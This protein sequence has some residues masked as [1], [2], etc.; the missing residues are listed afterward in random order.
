MLR[1][2]SLML[3][4]IH[5][6]AAEPL[7]NIPHAYNVKISPDGQYLAAL[8]DDTHQKK[9]TILATDTLTPIYHFAP[10]DSQIGNFHWINP[11]RVVIELNERTGKIAPHMISEL[12]AVNYD[13]GQGQ[14]IFGERSQN[15]IIISGYSAHWLSRLSADDEHILIAKTESTRLGNST[16]VTKINVY[17]GGERTIKRSSLDDNTF[18]LDHQGNPRLVSGIDDDGKIKV[19]YSQ[20]YGEKWHPFA[21]NP[22]N[23]F[24]PLGFS[25]DNQHIYAVKSEAEQAPALYQYSVPTG[26]EKLLQPDLVASTY[27]LIHDNQVYGVRIDAPPATQQSKSKTPIETTESPQHIFFNPANPDSQLHQALMAK[28]KGAPVIITSRTNDNKHLVVYVESDT[29]AGDFYLVNSQSMQARLLFSA[30]N[31]Q[32]PKR[33]SH[34]KAALIAP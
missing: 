34:T 4:S 17:T 24:T 31:K 22:G 27:A 2:L 6:F 9:L 18:V 19:F 21:I 1:L 26:A 28:F 7:A 8:I 12:Y 23:S 20:G 32:A 3:L 5:A 25:E 16:E 11:Q 13:G 10:K 29:Y 14:M 30:A 15:G 33:M